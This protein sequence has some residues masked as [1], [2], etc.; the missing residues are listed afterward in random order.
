M[1]PSAILQR[2]TI[3][4]HRRHFSM[5][6]KSIDEEMIDMIFKRIEEEE[7]RREYRN[8]KPLFITPVKPL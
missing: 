3:T 7:K 2:D 1:Q 4:N 8:Y 6:Q 5:P